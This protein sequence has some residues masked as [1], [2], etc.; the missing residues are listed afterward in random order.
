MKKKK[1]NT[2]YIVLGV[3]IVIALLLGLTVRDVKE[4][5]QLNFF[6]KAIK[7]SGTFV[8]KITSYP[9]RLTKRKIKKH[10]EKNK[11]YHDYQ[12][13]KLKASKSDTYL[14]EIKE[15]Q[16]EVAD[17]KKQVE[18][19]NVLSE[20]SYVHANVT[21]RNVN[22]WYNTLII[23][24]G[25]KKGIKEGDAVVVNEGLVGKIIKVGNFSSTVKL[26]TTDELSNKISVKV[27]LDDKS[28]SGL[29]SN[30]DE[31]C[32]C[33][34]IEGISESDTI[35]KGMQV[36]TTGL[37]EA[38]PAGILVGNVKKVVMDKYDLTKVVQVTPTVDFDDI[39]MVAV[40]KREVK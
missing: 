11:M 20:Y 2:R 12:R 22:T 9:F 7:D 25:S 23:D 17:L 32:A 29:L 15:L 18:L 24:K 21:S 3:V 35:S 28:V 31:K 14:A 6:E 1:S 37:S 16:K 39:T 30:Y 13:L 4:G 10:K 33:Y 27:N 19:D 8:V 34:L 26:L 5:H 40:L 36:V 38:F